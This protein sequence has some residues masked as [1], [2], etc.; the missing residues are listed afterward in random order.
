MIQYT[1]IKKVIS[2]DSECPKETESNSNSNMKPELIVSTYLN[3]AQKVFLR[4]A[5]PKMWGLTQE[6]YIRPEVVDY[7]GEWY[8]KTGEDKTYYKDPETCNWDEVIASGLYTPTGVKVGEEELYSTEEERKIIG[9]KINE[10]AKIIA[11]SASKKNDK[12]LY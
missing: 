9:Q 7:K 3:F 11:D 10:V 8:I 12:R 5:A 6:G 1:D 4:L 2:P